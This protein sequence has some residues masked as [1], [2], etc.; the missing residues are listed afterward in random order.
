MLSNR[1]MNLQCI[2]TDRYRK[3][4]RLVIFLS[5]LMQSCAS[6]QG[7]DYETIRTAIPGAV[8][9]DPHKNI[10]L[11]FYN[12]EGC[13]PCNTIV[14]NLTQYTAYMKCFGDN[15][16]IVFPSI[17]RGRLA[18]YDRM[19]KE[20]G[21]VSVSYINDKKLYELLEQKGK[22]KFGGKPKWIGLNEATK[23]SVCFNLKDMYLTD[24]IF[25]YFR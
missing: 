20:Y 17:S 6:W 14:G 11:I 16:F 3:S 7:G 4:C 25:A 1:N 19:L 2:N 24:S 9:L 13:P 22:D 8:Q 18:D 5:I 15:S 12:P 10:A 23:E 21:N